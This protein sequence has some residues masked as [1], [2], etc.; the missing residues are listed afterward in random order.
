MEKIL[1][2][3]EKLIVL[4]VIQLVALAFETRSM[5][6]QVDLLSTV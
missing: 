3:L 6:H 1:A 4:I 2:I 5:S